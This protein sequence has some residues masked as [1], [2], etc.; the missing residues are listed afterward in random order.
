MIIASLVVTSFVSGT[1]APPWFTY[2]VLAFCIGGIY[3]ARL[4]DISAKTVVMFYDFEEELEGAFGRLHDAADCLSACRKVWHI[5]SSGKVRDRKYHAGASEIVSR[6]A[7]SVGRKQPPYVKSNVEMISMS[8]GTQT[9]YFFPD[10]LLI[11]DKRG[12][13]AVSYDTLEIDISQQ[14]FIEE[15]RVEKDAEVVDRTWK[16]VNKKGGPDKRFKDNPQYPIC[17][18]DEIALLRSTGLNE[19]FPKMG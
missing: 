10:R 12:V 3:F 17:L 1:S 11:Y 4:R 7:T 9:L 8:V 2:V 19:H 5:E 15:T 18:Y 6:K 13:G 14:R 16:Y